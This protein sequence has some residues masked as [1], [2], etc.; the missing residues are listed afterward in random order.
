MA[1]I[2]TPSSVGKLALSGTCPRGQTYFPS[3]VCF[4]LIPRFDLLF[5]DDNPTQQFKL[6][7]T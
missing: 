1:A 3:N 2:E 7:R 4:L 5:M 6:P